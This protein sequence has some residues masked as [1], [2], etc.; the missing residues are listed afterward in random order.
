[1]K[2]VRQLSRP[3]AAQLEFLGEI[4]TLLRGILSLLGQANEVLGLNLPQKVGGED[5]EASE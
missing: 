2:H 1:M 5:A 3:R 4:I